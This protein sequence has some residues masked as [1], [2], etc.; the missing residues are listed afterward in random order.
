MSEHQVYEFKALDGTLSAK[1]K[2]YVRGLSSRAKVSSNSA[3]FVYNYG[4]F[5]SKP[6]LLLDRCFDVMVYFASYGVRTVMLRFP[7]GSISERSLQPYTIDYLIETSSTEKSVILKLNIVSEDY[8]VWID[9]DESW[10]DELSELRAEI[11]QGDLRSLYLSWLKAGLAED[12]PPAAELMEPPIPPNLKK[13]SPALDSLT[14]FFKIDD[15]MIA[16]AAESS[17]SKKAKKEPIADWIAALSE[18]DRNAYLLR[19]AQGET[20]VGAELMQRLRKE[21]GSTPKTNGVTTGRT[22][23]EIIALADTQAEERE[24]KEKAAAEQLRKTYLQSLVPKV[25]RLWADVFRLIGYKQAKPYEE[26]VE[27]LKDLKDVA[28]MQGRS[29]QF[30]DR[31]AKLMSD[32][33][34]RSGLLRRIRNANLHD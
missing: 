8:Y 16:I 3:Y 18:R 24:K 19:V 25:D 17:A 5:R 6:Q 10:I 22:F 4:D 28:R 20:H 9:D 21:F 12:A 15:D 34:S 1:D 27:I 30:R 31:M 32:Y 33:S 11:L 14:K 29:N 26:A 23:A 2:E 7:K 13:L